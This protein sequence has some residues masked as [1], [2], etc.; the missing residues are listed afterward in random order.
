MPRKPNPLLN[1][2]LDKSI[3]MPEID[4]ETVPPD[5]NPADAWDMYDETVEGWVPVWFPTF[6]PGGGRSYG[7]FERAHL[8]N[9]S[10]ERILKA[11]KRWPLWGS[12]SQKKYA[13]AVALLQ[14][15]CEIR[16]R[17]PKV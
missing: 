13:V 5:V 11:M 1:E 2:F 3:D 14:L 16:G 7:E 9:E 12:P 8:F 6:G 4:W 10:L 17:C 15:Y